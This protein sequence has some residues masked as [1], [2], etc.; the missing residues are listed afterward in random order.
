MFYSL[1]RLLTT[2]SVVA[3]NS[4]VLPPDTHVSAIYAMAIIPVILI[5]FVKWF[6]LVLEWRLRS[7]NAMVFSTP[8]SGDVCSIN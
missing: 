6:S 4:N 2:D 8:C 3:S 5:N 1:A 7:A